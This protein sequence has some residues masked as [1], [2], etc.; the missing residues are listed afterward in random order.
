MDVRQ[1]FIKHAQGACTAEEKALLIAYLQQG[2]SPGDLPDPEELGQ[3]TPPAPMGAAA[4]E[5][6]LENV[7]AIPDAPERGR[8]RK[9]VIQWTAA[10]AVIAAVILLAFLW[11]RGHRPAWVSRHTGYGEISKITLPDGSIITLNANSIL[12]YDSA[13]PR[14][15]A[16]EVW[17]QGEAFFDVAPDASGKFAVH[18]G[19]ALKIAVLGTQF[20]VRSGDST[21]Q[22]VLNS[23]RV[24]ISAEN[25]EHTGN[26]LLLQPGEMAVYHRSGLL[27]KQ[28]ADTVA[29]TGWKDNR[30]TF[31]GTS[32]EEIAALVH[33]QFGVEVMFEE[34]QLRTLPF[35][36]TAPANDLELLL[37]ILE[38][39]LDIRIDKSGGQIVIR[40][41]H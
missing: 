33:R 14:H 18:A 23:G 26:T 4:S 37:S 32:L 25:S 35:T 7:L 2:G 13:M 38:R 28:A 40:P 27:N 30:L 22:V 39:S 15:A 1:L 20:N 8:Y 24:K 19:E 6:V 29:L 31:H 5:R 9:L 34:A 36:G 10:A 16:R 3:V 21:V 41:A 17:L 11:Q 12:K